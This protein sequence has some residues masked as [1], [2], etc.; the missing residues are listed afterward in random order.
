MAGSGW[1]QSKD[2]VRKEIDEKLYSVVEWS[3]L[4]S[5]ES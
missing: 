5:M 2:E 3:F 1:E 4:A